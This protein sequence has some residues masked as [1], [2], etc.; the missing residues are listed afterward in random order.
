MRRADNL[1]AFMYRL[2]RSLGASTYWNPQG[3]SR[4]V[5]GLLFAQKWHCRR[6]YTIY[7]IQIQS[8]KERYNPVEMCE[9]AML[10]SCRFRGWEMQEMYTACSWRTVGKRQLG[11]PGR[12]E[13]NT[14][15][16]RLSLVPCSVLWFLFCCAE[17]P[18]SAT[19][20]SAYLVC[21]YVHLCVLL[22][23]RWPR[24]TPCLINKLFY[25]F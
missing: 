8:D 3:L 17:V 16:N 22:C 12:Y 21:Q 13:V 11:R 9:P 4:P 18:R 1:T 2:S 14:K 6:Q 10:W 19:T 23:C 15:I 5:M 25:L 24:K 20:Q 7:F